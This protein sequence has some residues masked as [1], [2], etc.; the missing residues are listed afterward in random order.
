MESPSEAGGLSRIEL[1]GATITGADLTG[2]VVPRHQLLSTTLDWTGTNFDSA[3]NTIQGDR[4]D[5]T[6]VDFV[7][8][9][10]MLTGANLTGADLT[11]ANLTGADLTGTILAGTNLALANLLGATG[12]PTGG[13]TATYNTTTCPNGTITDGATN[14]TCVGHGFQP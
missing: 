12:D 4:L 13:S 10:R 9:G 2:A 11:G 7:A 1:S 14:P 5:L 6:N 8:T 3:K